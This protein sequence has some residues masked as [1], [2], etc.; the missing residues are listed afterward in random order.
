MQLRIF[1]SFLHLE[2]PLY[3]VRYLD[4]ERPDKEFAS[5]PELEA[6]LEAHVSDENG[7]AHESGISLVFATPAEIPEVTW[8]PPLERNEPV[9]VMELDDDE[10]DM[11][12]QFVRGLARKGVAHASHVA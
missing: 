3:H 6:C 10:R 4:S 12:W 1:K 5:I 9:R 2:D 8:P 7:W 11:I